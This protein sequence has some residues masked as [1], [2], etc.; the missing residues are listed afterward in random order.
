MFLSMLVIIMINSLPFIARLNPAVDHIVSFSGTSFLCHSELN[1][2]FEK[3]NVSKVFNWDAAIV[4]TEYAAEGMS[5][6]GNR[7]PCCVCALIT[8]MTAENYHYYY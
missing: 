2:Y 7:K 5:C 8:S 1:I 4:Y 6:I 3:I